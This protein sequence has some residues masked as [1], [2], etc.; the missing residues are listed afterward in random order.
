MEELGWN[1]D[2]HLVLN[3][4]GSNG[5]NGI[6][7]FCGEDPSTEC[8][9][10]TAQVSNNASVANTIWI[11]LHTWEER[12]YGADSDKNVCYQDEVGSG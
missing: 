1:F 4:D 12:T 8:K 3:D 5:T 9:R 2:S 6:W 10:Y 7:S 11:G